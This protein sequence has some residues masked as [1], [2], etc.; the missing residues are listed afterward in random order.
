MIEAHYSLQALCM[1][2]W[3]RGNVLL[4]WEM[5]VGNQTHLP[6]RDIHVDME[7][8]ILA[9]IHCQVQ[10]EPYDKA[11]EERSHKLNHSLRTPSSDY[12]ESQTMW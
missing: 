6:Y 10:S 5:E 9:C 11:I 4:V 8:C 7:V 2:A 12:Y 3:S 1:L